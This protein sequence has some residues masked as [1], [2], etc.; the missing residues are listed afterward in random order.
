MMAQPTWAF[1]PEVETREFFSP[2]T[3]ATCRQNP[4][5]RRPV[6]DSGGAGE[7]A[8]LMVNSTAGGGRRGAHQRGLAMARYSVAKK[9]LVVE[10]MRGRRCSSL[11]RRL[12]QRSVLARCEKEQR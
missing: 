10:R 9:K 5:G 12:V 11:D 8:R 7:K 1:W 2:S 4:T 6:V 3:P